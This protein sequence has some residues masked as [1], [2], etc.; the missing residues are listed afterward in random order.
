VQIDDNLSSAHTQLG[1]LA[2][3]Y[4]WDP[5][6]AE[7]HFER[8]LA[9]DPDNAEAHLFFAHLR[10]NQ[11]R[12]EEAMR[13]SA[14]A[15]ELEPFNSRFNALEGQ[16][17]VHAGRADDAIERLQAVIALDPNHVLA[18]IFIATAYIEKGRYA[19]A[20]S[21]SQLAA[22][23]TRRS[24]AHPLGILGYAL[25]K[26]GDVAQARAVL[27]ELLTA[28]RSRYVAPYGIALIYNALGERD[29]ALAWL[30]RGF[31]ARDHK[32]NLL[33]VDPKWKNLHGDVRFQD[34]V[35]R[36]GF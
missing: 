1:M 11:A 28:S 20:I 31:E 23:R 5:I 18:R 35:R 7:R 16:F 13:E 19:E 17:L 25:V 22:E 10:S 2:T 24:M 8:A 14:R 6:A 27:E 34:L 4:D 32:M 36:I 3:W 15:L 29:E 33:K 30:E 12:H 21:E 26:S 9:L